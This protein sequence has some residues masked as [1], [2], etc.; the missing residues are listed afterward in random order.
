MKIRQLEAMRAVVATGTTTQA[1]EIMGLTQSAVS[2][3]ISQLEDDLGFALFDRHRGRLAITPEGQEFFNAAERILDE[4]DQIRDTAD[5]IRTHGAGTIRIA[6]MPAIGTCMLPRPLQMLQL[7]HKRLNVVVHLKNRS[8]LQHAVADRQYDIGLATLPI[9]EQGLTVEPLCRVRSVLIMPFGHRLAD[10]QT[11][12]AADLEGERFV[13]LS[14]DTVVRYR[15]EE[16]FT[17]LKI[18]R[19]L[20]VEAQSTILMGN[21]VELGLGV[22]VVHPFVADHFAGKVEIRPFEPAIEVS[23]GL[24][25]PEGSRRLRIVDNLAEKMRLCFPD[26]GN[27]IA[28]LKV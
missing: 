20:A 14:A 13:S 9:G 21:L 19:Q 7:E 4:V 8:E 25:Y 23:Y 10:K 15:T 24:V 22:A 1:A 27:V 16:L 18:D 17:R 12:T 6:A 5:N 11:V 26:T 28:D 3:L 2:R